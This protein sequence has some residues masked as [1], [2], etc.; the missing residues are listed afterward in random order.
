MNFSTYGMW[1]TGCGKN[2]LYSKSKVAPYN[3]T[4]SKLNDLNFRQLGEKQGKSVARSAPLWPQFR[5]M[6]NAT[7]WR[8]LLTV[9]QVSL[10]AARTV[11]FFSL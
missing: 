4:H 9:I 2:F 1:Q 7:V 3:E 10:Y 5:P 8:K 11:N 6:A